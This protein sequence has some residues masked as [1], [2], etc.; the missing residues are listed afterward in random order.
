MSNGS[1]MVGGKNVCLGNEVQHSAQISY[2]ERGDQVCCFGCVGLI[3]QLIFQFYISSSSSPIPAKKAQQNCLLY[4]KWLLKMNLVLEEKE[5][6]GFS[7]VMDLTG[8]N[9][10][11][12]V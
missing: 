5:R 11:F 8:K 2:A 3:S 7:D 6:W 4:Q 12:G 9:Q 1:V 10:N